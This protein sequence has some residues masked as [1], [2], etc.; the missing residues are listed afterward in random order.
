MTN[1]VDL[2]LDADWKEKPDD[3]GIGQR[4]FIKKD[5]L[6][7]NLLKVSKRGLISMIVG[8]EKPGYAGGL[9]PRDFKR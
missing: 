1:D 7:K 8:K 3:L 5:S 4:K 9:I 6:L 2:N